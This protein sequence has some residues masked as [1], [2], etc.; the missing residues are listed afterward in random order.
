MNVISIT[1]KM[2]IQTIL[3]LSSI[4][5]MISQGADDGI[6]YGCGMS[7]LTILIFIPHSH[8]LMI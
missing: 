3:I 5:L 2:T 1:L 4:S 6:S 7:L 8:E